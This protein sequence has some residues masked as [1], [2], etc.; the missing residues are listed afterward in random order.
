M[1]MRERLALFCCPWAG[2]RQVAFQEN[3]AANEGG[4]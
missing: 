3:R 1:S 2:K 4:F